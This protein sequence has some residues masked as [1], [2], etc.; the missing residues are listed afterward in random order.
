M[1]EE[2]VELFS[3]PSLALTSFLKVWNGSYWEASATIP[4]LE[5]SGKKDLFGFAEI[6]VVNLMRSLASAVVL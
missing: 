1:V 6:S 4:G 3:E 2:S 5:A